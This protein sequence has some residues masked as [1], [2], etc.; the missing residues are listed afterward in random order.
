MGLFYSCCHGISGTH[1]FI[2]RD[3]GSAFCTIYA[4]SVELVLPGIRWDGK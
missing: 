4:P 1:I 2:E 3:T